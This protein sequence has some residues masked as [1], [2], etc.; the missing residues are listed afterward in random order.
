MEIIQ[1]TRSKN[2]NYWFDVGTITGLLT[3]FLILFPCM[4]IT[5]IMIMMNMT[6]YGAVVM[7]IYLIC[8]RLKL[9]QFLKFCQKLAIKEMNGRAE[10]QSIK[11][12]LK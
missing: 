5:A 4:V 6:F 12:L 10:L 7:L 2:E 8:L 3:M 1:L 11:E 9:N